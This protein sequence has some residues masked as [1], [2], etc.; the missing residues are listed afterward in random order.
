MRCNFMAI[1]CVQRSDTQRNEPLV[2]AK[3]KFLWNFLTDFSIGFD[4]ELFFF[5]ENCLEL[6]FI[7]EIS[8]II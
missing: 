4:W 6:S 7:W 1:E 2:A 5:I 3:Y 8:F